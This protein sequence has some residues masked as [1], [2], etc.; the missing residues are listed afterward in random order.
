MSES[1][2][3]RVPTGFD[4]D[5]QVT[6]GEC[7]TVLA[8][9][10][11]VTSGQRLLEAVRLLENDMRVQV[12]FTQAPD[13]HGNGVQDFL[14]GIGALQISWEQAT[15]LEFDLA[16]AASLGAIHR[17]RAPLI[18]MP[19]GVGHAK[20]VAR[21]RGRAVGSRMVYGLDAQR[22]LH[23][24][25][26]VP[27]AVVLP[28]QA[29]VGV[30]A[31]S[32]PEALPAAEV[33]GDPCYDR[34]VVSLDRRP[35]YQM[36]L[37][38]GDGRKLVVV[39]STWGPHS[40][41]GRRSDLWPRLLTELPDDEFQVVTLLHPNV[42]FGYGSWQVKTWLAGCLRRGLS[43]VPPEA[44]WRGVLTAADIVIGDHGSTTVYGAAIGVPVLL[45]TFTS[46]EVHPRSPAARLGDLAPRIGTRGSLRRQVSRTL[47]DFERGRYRAVAERVTSEPGRFN[48]R[49]RRLMYR[50]LGLHQPATVPAT[51]P[52]VPPFLIKE[53]GGHRE[54]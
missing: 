11:T 17:V 2:W 5:R 30:L 10:H 39:A 49:M 16:V 42:W 44:D 6:R 26:L 27:E 34:M 53:Q 9:V 37:G 48:R 50:M 14:L 35:L 4:A 25:A 3:R 22:L 46:S 28:H 12:V 7:K 51:L 21:G 33:I 32:C 13:D 24:G 1:E 29:E 54:R 40:L 23:D 41:L 8:L 47:A 18:V 43:L 31:R 36:A 20:L 45:G 19:H 52:V 38:A 15:H